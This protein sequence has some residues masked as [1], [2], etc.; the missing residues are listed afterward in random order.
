MPSL[1]FLHNLHIMY[2]VN[3]R[4]GSVSAGFRL[5]MSRVVGLAKCGEVR[6][7]KWFIENK[8]KENLHSKYGV[9]EMG[10]L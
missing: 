4:W 8:K 3:N 2:D 1:K 6:W 9:G 5:K 7:R 10:L